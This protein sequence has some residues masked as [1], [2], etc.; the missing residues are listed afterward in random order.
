MDL[1]DAVAR[2]RRRRTSARDLE[3]DAGDLCRP[4]LLDRHRQR[5]LQPIVRSARLQ[6]VPER[7]SSAS[8]PTCYLGVYRPDTFWFDEER[9]SDAAIHPLAHRRHDPDAADHLGAGLH[10]HR[11]AAGRLFRELHRRAAGAG[12]RRRHASKIECLR[13][14][15]RLRPAA[16][17][18]LLLLGRRHAA[19]RFRLFLRIP[20]AGRATWSA[21]GCG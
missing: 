4:G 3:R 15:I 1:L 17:R 18:A 7:A 13:E 20:A 6:N 11:A 21:T 2:V 19:R 16:G 9:L 14:R 12:R 8:S 10:H 5:T